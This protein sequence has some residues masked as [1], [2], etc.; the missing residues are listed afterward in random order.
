MSFRLKHRRPA[1][2][3][4]SAGILASVCVVVVILAGCAAPADDEM[5]FYQARSAFLEIIDEVQAQIPGEWS[6][7]QPGSNPCRTP[8]GA[9]GANMSTYRHGP[10]VPD[11]EQHAMLDRIAGI[12]EDY[13]YPLT[14]S[15]MAG[16]SGAMVEGSYPASGTADSGAHVNVIVSANG[17]SLSGSSE[18]GTGNSRE[19]NRDRQENGGYPGE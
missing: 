18:C 7:S 3:S 4:R 13:D 17:T 12:L 5:D 8:G 2:P 6:S 19:I 9:E 16:P 14:I 10:G 11:G 1:A 15:E